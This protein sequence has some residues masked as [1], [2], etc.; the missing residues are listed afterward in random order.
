VLPERGNLSF[1]RTGRAASF[2]GLG[3]LLKV[4]GKISLDTAQ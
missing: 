2:R 4:L 3:N 1:H